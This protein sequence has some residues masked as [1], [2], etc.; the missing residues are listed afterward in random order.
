M[1][2]QKIK[3]RVTETD[4]IMDVTVFS[5]REDRIEVVL[6]EGVH[7]VK[8]ELLPTPNGMA[9]VGSAMGR[10]I[11]YERSRDEVKADLE[12]ENHDYRDSRRR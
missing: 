12:V 7:S 3:V 5:K 10:E 6:G 1:N 4:M 11:V 2:D 8:C 9:Y